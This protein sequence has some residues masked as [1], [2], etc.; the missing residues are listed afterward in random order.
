MYSKEVWNE[1]YKTHISDAPWMSRKCADGHIAILEQYLD[2]VKG[3]KMLDYG[4]GNGL[5]A[6]HFFQKGAIVDLA[7][8]SDNL[9]VK[10]REKYEKEGI[11]VFQTVTP[12]DIDE[13]NGPYDIIIANSLFH[14]IHPAL[15]TNFLKGFADIMASGGLLL[16]SGWDES[17][18]FAKE[19]FAPYTQ[20]TTWPITTISQNIQRT[21]RF[22][23]IKEE[24]RS[25]EIPDYFKN[26]K[27]FKY[28]VLK[29]K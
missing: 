9:L 5:I 10:L 6:Y 25:I 22:D 17:D 29:K 2:D 14:H 16:L 8:I 15:W 1:I 7:D 19:K 27:I 26:N 12:Q 3:K 24:T 4:C 21:H 18:D 20:K 13:E 23:I 11:R 28:Y